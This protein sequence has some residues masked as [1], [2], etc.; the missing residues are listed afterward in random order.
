MAVDNPTNL[1][2]VVA[3]DST[4]V[5]GGFAFQRWEIPEHVTFGGPEQLVIHKQPGGARTID[6]MGRDDHPFKWSGHFLSADAEDRARRLE[7]LK[8]AGLKYKLLFGTYDPFVV[9]SNL[10]FVYH[11]ANLIDYEIECTPVFDADDAVTPQ[12]A[13]LLLNLPN[14]Q[15]ATNPPPT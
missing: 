2:N 14:A 12:Q 13:N 6:V 7:G 4:I 1:V 5:L 11:R 3:P 15:N 10:T 9:I 8:I